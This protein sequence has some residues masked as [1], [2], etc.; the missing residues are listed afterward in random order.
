MLFQVLV[1]CG[2]TIPSDE[3]PRDGELVDAAVDGRMDAFFDDAQPVDA[4]ALDAIHPPKDGA[5]SDALRDAPRGHGP[6]YP[7]VLA[8]GFFGFND[9][10]GLGFIDYFWNVRSEL[11]RAGERWVFTPAVDPFNDSEARGRELLRHIESILRETGAAKVNIIAHSQGGLD[12]RVVAHL[13][14]DLVASVTTISTPHRGT[15]VAD[16]ILEISD[17]RRLQDLIDAIVRLAAQPLW[18]AAGRETSLFRP[19]RLFSREGIAEFNARY[20]DAPGVRYHSIA[21]RSNRE[22]ARGLCDVPERP[23]FI[24][25]FEED[26]DPLEPLLLPALPFI[27]GFHDGLVP[28]ES[29]KHGV[30]LGCIP[31]DHMDEI[32]HFFGDSPGSGNRFNHLLFYRELVAWLRSQGL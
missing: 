28:V 14:P 21:G 32:G 13:R 9:F 23:A 20:P 6:P 25:R 19:I 4:L 17:R 24:R 12:A 26:L 5:P 30:F 11:I 1:G 29:A 22:R 16:A 18:D 7:I 2:S 3:P 27:D 15:P 10:A 8:H 31:A